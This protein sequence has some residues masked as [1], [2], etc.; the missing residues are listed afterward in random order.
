[1]CLLRHRRLWDNLDLRT[2]DL[3]LEKLAA[4][5]WPGER[6]DGSPGLRVCFV[7]GGVTASRFC[8]LK[9]RLFLLFIQFLFIACVSVACMGERWFM[10]A[11][12]HVD[13]MGQLCGVDS[14]HEPWRCDSGRWALR[15]STFP[16]SHLPGP[17]A[18]L[19]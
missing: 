15:T 2:G 4:W 17:A 6:P 18:V 8:S 12:T 13:V 11:T 19:P 16:R 7:L 14:L 10:C 3:L 5:G 9:L 1:M